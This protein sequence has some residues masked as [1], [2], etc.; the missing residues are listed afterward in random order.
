[1]TY[2]KVSLKHEDE[3]NIA[4]YCA[5][6]NIAFNIANAYDVTLAAFKDNPITC[7]A[8][9][10][11]T[12]V[13]QKYDITQRIAR[14]IEC[15]PKTVERIFEKTA[16]QKIELDK[17]FF[18]N[19]IEQAE[20]NS[21]PDIVKLV[22]NLYRLNIV[23]EHSYLA[24]VCFLMQLKH[25][26]N[27][28]MVENDKTCVFFNGIARNGKS[29]T[30]EAISEVES[31]Y[32]VVFKA[33]TGKLLESTHEEQVWK[34][35]LNYFDEIKPT[36]VDRD[37]LLN[38]VNGGNVEL[39]PKNKPQYNYFVNTNNI[40]TSNAQISLM[41]RRVS[42]IKFGHRLDG[43]PLAEGTLKNIIKNIMDSLPSFD[44]YYDLYDI[45]SKHNEKRLNP[46]AISCILKYMSDKF[47]FINMTDERIMTSEIQFSP[48]N[49][50]DCVKDSYSKQILTSERKEAIKT[51]LRYLRDRGL[52]TEVR[53]PNC[54]TIFYKVTAPNYLEIAEEYNVTNTKDE[55][56]TKITRDE[57]YNSLLRF[58]VDNPNPSEPT[59]PV[60]CDDIPTE[61][62]TTE[63]NLTSDGT[64][65][66]M[67]GADV[68]EK[69]E[70]LYRK[71]VKQLTA[72]KEKC[73]INGTDFDIDGALKRY[74]TPDICKYL[75]HQTLPDMLESS[76]NNCYVDKNLFKDLYMH[77][78]GITDEN[79]LEISD[80]YKLAGN[81]YY[82]PF[83]GNTWCAIPPTWTEYKTIEDKHTFE[84]RKKAE[85]RKEAAKAQKEKRRL[86]KER[87]RQELENKRKQ[88]QENTD[89]NLVNRD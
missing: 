68:K 11:A 29:A 43:R 39:N 6:N 65:V 2:N 30:A 27:N 66:I 85:R 73:D 34:S 83:S 89:K 80:N 44:R 55:D 33:H 64:N 18:K 13:P 45:V 71:L 60:S 51:A 58:F 36:D 20:K 74:I 84:E 86:E 46:L 70:I 22:D 40:F 59:T 42:I 82:S 17:E 77:H 16:F 41:Q 57:L 9:D 12:G 32:G 23:D 87:K 69:G 52:I 50:Y 8:V 3:T 75:A 48:T 19:N 76:L 4:I 10:P 15:Q 25:L 35:H 7:F 49:I 24:L 21:K 72:E 56:N 81:Y 14:L 1:M 53:Y 79:L 78:L 67:V 26:R 62:I 31:Q 54:T 38:L 47:G 5:K 88:E 61:N 37:M 63:N 28:V